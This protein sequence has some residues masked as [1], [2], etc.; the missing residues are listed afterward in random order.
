MLN[1]GILLEQ[2]EPPDL[3]GAR[4]WYQR[5]ADA[6][7]TDAITWAADVSA[8]M[9]DAEGARAAW[10][11]GVDS[12]VPGV[13]A[14]AVAGAALAL[15]ALDALAGNTDRS[16]ELLDLAGR[17]G[18]DTAAACSAALSPDPGIRDA[19]LLTLARLPDDSDAL[20]FLGIASHRAGKPT[21]ARHYWVAS[22]QLGDSVAPLL[23]FT[24]AGQSPGLP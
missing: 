20:N 22:A 5:A 1:L 6:G 12:D 7:D 19:A 10:Q 18:A 24:D 13:D 3:N 17:H 15:A 2:Q 16:V 11:R 14:A 21:E 8:R 4:T 23:L 9:G